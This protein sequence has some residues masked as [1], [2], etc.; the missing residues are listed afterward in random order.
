M[1]KSNKEDDNNSITKPLLR[2]TLDSQNDDVKV[3]EVQD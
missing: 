3:N 1:I 2:T